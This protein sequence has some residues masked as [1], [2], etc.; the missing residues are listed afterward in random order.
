MRKTFLGLTLFAIS[1]LLMAQPGK[2]KAQKP[3]VTVAKTLADSVSYILG[4]NMGINLTQTGLGEMKLNY[5]LFNKGM[6]EVLEG[7]KP[8][9][10]MI[11]ET[12]KI[13]LLIAR[14]KEEK[15]KAYPLLE[16]GRIF[17]ASNKLRPSVFTTKSGL[18]YEIIIQGRGEK[19][20]ASD[21]FVCRYLVTLQ[22][23][24]IVDST[25]EKGPHLTMP[26]NQVFSGL[27]EALLLM[28]VG[29]KY[30]FYMHPELAYGMKGN[31][32]IPG[33]AV[34]IFEIDLWGIKKK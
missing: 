24:R 11:G 8:E 10:D 28:P 7:M 19:M 21:T 33:G 6:K 5:V 3:A 4:K 15:A 26:V 18:Q 27:K 32:E 23:G 16:S 34:V 22:D 17:M 31:G 25:Y 14:L 9:P 2:P 12:E 30:K 13:K 20:A 29:S 1:H